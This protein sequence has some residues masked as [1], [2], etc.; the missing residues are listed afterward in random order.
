MEG[1]SH[2]AHGGAEPCF[3]WT[4]PLKRGELTAPFLLRRPIPDS[5]PAPVCTPERLE[6]AAEV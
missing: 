4:A 6:W 2:A 1:R 5:P 3:A